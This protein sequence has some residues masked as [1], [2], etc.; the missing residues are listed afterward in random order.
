[1]ISSQKS[2]IFALHGTIGTINLEAEP[3]LATQNAL[4]KRPAKITAS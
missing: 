3:R 2:A 4:E 1:M